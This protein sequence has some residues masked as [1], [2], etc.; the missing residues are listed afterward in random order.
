M[1]GLIDVLLSRR[2][3]LIKICK[4]RQ[5][6]R[7]VNCA[8]RGMPAYLFHGLFLQELV[9]PE[10]SRGYRVATIFFTREDALLAMAI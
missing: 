9:L 8:R 5:T 4:P 1:A 6:P 2:Q 7:G 3:R 10:S